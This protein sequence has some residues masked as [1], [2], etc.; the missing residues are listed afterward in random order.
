MMD[1][2]PLLTSYTSKR[3][4]IEKHLHEFKAVMKRPEEELFAELVFC[5][6]TPQSRAKLCDK[7]VKNLFNSKA[8]YGKASEIKKHLKGMVRFHNEKT[9]HIIK[10]REIFLNGGIGFNLVGNPPE[11]R[12][13]LAENVYGL[14]YKESS[15]FLRNIGM[16]EELAILDRHILRNL[17]KYGVIKEIPKSLTRKRYVEIEKKMKEFSNVVGIP[18]PHLD[19]LF[20]SEETDEIFK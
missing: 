11:V 17:V 12:E 7:A 10:A 20:W 15:H 5:I 1:F 4:E 19:L 3:T 13:W 8:I 14:G 6:L 9:K 2:A 18:L 16:G